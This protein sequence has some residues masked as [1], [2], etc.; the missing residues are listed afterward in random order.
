MLG[1]AERVSRRRQQ[2]GLTQSGLARR[3]NVKPQSIQQLET[4]QVARPRY[5]LELARALGIDAEW[6]VTGR[7]GG[8]ATAQTL[9]EPGEFALVPVYDLRASAGAGSFFDE[10]NVLYRLAFRQQWLKSSSNAPI[11]TLAVLEAA[12]DSMED[13]IRH[14]DTLLI[15]RTQTSPR[16]DAIFVLRWDGQ[17]LVKRVKADPARKRLT[18]LSDNPRYGAVEDIRPNDL[19]VLGRV[20]WI[21]R[22]V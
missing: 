13:T 8:Q 9:G 3:L 19:D 4:G 6:L 16:V 18:L 15:D 20:I 14:G 5:M 1:I 17:L 21:G 10:E 11:E 2:L 7:A 12:G 22:R